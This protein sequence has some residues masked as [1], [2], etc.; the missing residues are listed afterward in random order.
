[1]RKNAL[2]TMHKAPSQTCTHTTLFLYHTLHSITFFLYCFLFVFMFLLPFPNYAPC[3]V[4]EG[5]F[6]AKPCFTHFT[7][8]T[9]SESN[10]CC[11]RQPV[12][13]GVICHGKTNTM[14]LTPIREYLL[15]ALLPRTLKSSLLN[16]FALTI[17]ILKPAFLCFRLLCVYLC[18][19]INEHVAEGKFLNI[20]H[21]RY[22]LP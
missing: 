1:M 18:T 3:T 10:R 9:T 4:H 5:L 2:C 6:A 12:Y 21:L 17:V 15:L 11:C 13:F 20:N 7:L 16:V 14:A 22:S 8:V 19:I